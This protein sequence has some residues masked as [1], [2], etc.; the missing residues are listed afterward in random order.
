MHTGMRSLV[1]S[2]AAMLGGFA[3][4]EPPVGSRTLAWEKGETSLALANQ[5]KVV[6]RLVFDPA[7][8]KSYFH[9]LASIDGHV[10]T[11]FEP[12]DHRWHRGLW[13]SWKFING[14]NYWEEDPKTGKS[15]GLTK[16]VGSEVEAAEDFSAKVRLDFAYQLPGQAPLLT[17]K[18]HLHIHAPDDD[19]TYVIDW[20]SIFTAADA[21]VKLDRTLP[22][23]LGGVGY[24]GYAGLSLRLAQGL[25]GYTFRN[26]D[27]ETTA[28]A[29]H[30]K[31]AR[32]MEMAGADSG[33][34]ILDHPGNPRHAPPW[35]LHSSKT[36]TFFSPTPLFNEPLEIAPG[37]SI[38]MAYRVIV[39]S[40][41]LTPDKIEAQWKA[42][43]PAQ[44]KKP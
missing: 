28:A 4:A 30:G 32:W 16:L 17:E 8:P 18:R 39:H 42:Y 24:G 35:Y 31:N 26:A 34:A 2:L 33:I 15:A 20:N 13:W 9:P 43:T 11:A 37:K 25:E 5:G 3:A 29:S 22:A 23:H 21:L 10:L 27:G 41:R 6:W 44:P 36:M 7:Q 40:V 38:S 1:V 12:A 19:G 14:V